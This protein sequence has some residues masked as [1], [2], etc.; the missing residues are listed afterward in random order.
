MTCPRWRRNLSGLVGAE[1]ARFIPVW[2]R[3]EPGDISQDFFIE[4]EFYN[5]W[6]SVKKYA[7]K[8]EQIHPSL[9]NEPILK[10]PTVDLAC[11]GLPRKLAH[12]YLLGA[13]FLIDHLE[14]QWPMTL[15]WP[16]ATVTLA[17]SEITIRESYNPLYPR[18][19]PDPYTYNPGELVSRMI[20]EKP[21]AFTHSLS[22]WHGHYQTYLNLTPTERQF[23]AAIDNSGH[24][25][26]GWIEQK[27]NPQRYF[28]RCHPN[29]YGRHLNKLESLGLITVSRQRDGNIISFSF[30]VSKTG[31][32]I[33]VCQRLC[34]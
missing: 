25:G 28:P 22:F 26:K 24:L 20:D 21:Q 5:W 34:K 29:H 31:N 33:H 18:P 2:V 6:Q 19:V 16:F 7:L 1:L 32:L 8:L 15:R 30:Q 17:D 10:P 14:L 11:T 13:E 12:Y 23:L 9:S 27:W 4:L 3:L